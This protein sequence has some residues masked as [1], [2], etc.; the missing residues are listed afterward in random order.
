MIK[1][2]DLILLF[3]KQH[4]LLYRVFCSFIKLDPGDQ[5]NLN[6]IERVDIF[7]KSIG[8]AF[9]LR[10][11]A[12]KNSVPNNQETAM[13]FIKV[14]QVGAVV[15]PVMGGSIQKKFKKPGQAVY[16]FGMNPELVN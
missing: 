3:G 1:K 11:E 16:G 9:F 13:V 10:L 7:C 8:W 5:G 6:W 12:A 15:H 4:T 2:G 14:F